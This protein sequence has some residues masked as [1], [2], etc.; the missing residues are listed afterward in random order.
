MATAHR[1][2]GGDLKSSSGGEL[3]LY[4]KWKRNTS[5]LILVKSHQFLLVQNQ[6]SIDART[7]VE[8]KFPQL[9]LQN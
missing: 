7:K 3:K 4:L 5:L 8:L 2:S 9:A 1:H 6:E